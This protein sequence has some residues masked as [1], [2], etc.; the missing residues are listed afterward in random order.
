MVHLIPL[1]NCPALEKPCRV[2]KY[3]LIWCSSGTMTLTVDGSDSELRGN[4]VITITSGQI[5]YLKA[6]NEAK[7]YL[8]EF[9]LDFFCKSDSDTELIFHNGLFCHFGMNEVIQLQN[10]GVAAQLGMIE[11]ELIKLPYQHLISVHSHIGL[12]LVEINR[13]KVDR[14]DKIWKPDA[15][16]LRFLELI[17]SN[18]EKSYSPGQAATILRTTET[19]LNDL[20]R[21][22]A[23][24]T[25]QQV[26][27]GL[28]VSEA[29]RVLT[30][31]NYSIKEVAWQLGFNDPFYFSNFF[32]K[33]TGLSPKAYRTQCA[34]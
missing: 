30:Y 9:T 10:E 12:I 25:A 6:S 7:G 29:K 5:H 1:E 19:R 20:A 22:H 21:L 17:R 24:K 23:G 2:M 11:D 16:F 18:Y 3:R 27:H 28:I 8:L 31:E 4:S 26:I 33:H 34:I 14:G 13:T 32:K 15:L